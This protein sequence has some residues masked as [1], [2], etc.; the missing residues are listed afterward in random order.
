MTPLRCTRRSL[1]ALGIAPLAPGAAAFIEQSAAAI[2]GDRINNF[3]RRRIEAKGIPGAAVAVVRNGEVM[4]VQAYGLASLEFRI[5]ASTD[6]LLPMASSSKMI[7]A[8]AAG[9]LHEAGKVDLDAPVGDYLTDF[10][11][12]LSSVRIWH[13]LSHT[14]GLRGP[15][16]N[17]E[18]AT[19]AAER[20]RREAYVGDLKLDFFTNEEILGYGAAAGLSEPPGASWKYSQFPYFVFGQVLSRVTGKA[21]QE[22]VREDVLAPLG[23]HSARYGDHRTI[24]EHRY[25]TNYTR[26]YGPL[27]NFALKYTPGYWPAAGLNISPTEAAKLLLGLQPGRLLR[28]E[29][30]ARLWTPISLNDGRSVDYGLGFALANSDGR[31][32]VGHEGGGCSYFGWWPSEALGIAVLLNLSGSREDGIELELAQLILS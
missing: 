32:S 3:M 6:T 19:L 11:G 31:S 20:E 14:S 5:P 27:Q 2:D 30:L 7:A 15:S 24:V 18:F 22:V 1:L 9:R 21:Y 25:P 23:I 26:Q 4:K 13:L 10:A 29:T 16:A 12:E 8:L 28:R 17:P